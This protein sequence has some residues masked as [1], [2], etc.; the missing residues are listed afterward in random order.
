MNDSMKKIKKLSV[1]STTFFAIS[2]TG[3]SFA[4]GLFD[5]VL[6]AVVEKASKD[7]IS[8][9]NGNNQEGINN[10][11]SAKTNKQ[12][13]VQQV[14]TRPTKENHQHV[15]Y[16]D[17]HA[18]VDTVKGDDG[19]WL[20]NCSV[21][22]GGDGI[23]VIAVQIPWGNVDAGTG[24]TVDYNEVTYRNLPTSLQGKQEISWVVSTSKGSY[25]YRGETYTGHDK[26]GHPYAINRIQGNIDGGDSLKMLRAF[27]KGSTVTLYDD[28]SGGDIH[29]ASLSGFSASYRKVSQWCGFSP[30]NVLKVAPSH[31]T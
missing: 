11:P 10:A 30:D 2:Y 19:E 12:Q 29:S 21:R 9:I 6:E 25:S 5:N 17:W 13:K 31:S 22:T 14:F 1:V 18:T 24:P 28:Y 7:I 23:S 16:K 20:T 26:T 3:V 4:A 8:G 15:T 27:A